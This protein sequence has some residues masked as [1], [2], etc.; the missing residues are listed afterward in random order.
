MAFEGI[1]HGV[2]PG[3]LRRTRHRWP[4]GDEGKQG[5]GQGSGP[6]PPPHS[7][8]VTCTITFDLT[9]RFRMLDMRWKALDRAM[10]LS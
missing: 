4:L 7:G 3:E 6:A 8:N 10:D 5:L 1:V 2:T 9:C